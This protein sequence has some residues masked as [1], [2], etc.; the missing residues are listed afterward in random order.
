MKRVSISGSVRE[1][2]GK[3]DAKRLRREGKVVCVIYG[4]KEQK[5][6]SVEEN[7]FKKLVYTPEVY[8]VDLDLDGEKYLTILQDVQYH[9]V[10]DKTLHVDFLQIIEGKPVTVELPVKIDGI[11]PGVMKGGVLNKKLNTIPVKGLIEDMPESFVIDI[12]EM[13]I[14]DSVKVGDVDF[15]KLIAQIP[16]RLLVVGVKTARG[17]DEDEEDEEDEE[18][19]EGSEEGAKEGEASDAAPKEGD[20]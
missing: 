20:K 3:K 9:P 4:G 11:A 5:H 12:S 14:N 1:N 8:I 16:D 6:F 17:A 10:T 2:V 15:G 19:E 18:G 7:A 13:E